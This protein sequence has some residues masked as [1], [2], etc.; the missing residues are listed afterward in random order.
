M[1]ISYVFLKKYDPSLL[2]IGGGDIFILC[3]FISIKILK[4]KGTTAR[5]NAF[6]YKQTILRSF[7]VEHYVKKE[8]KVVSR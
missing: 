3:L 7:D 6:T 8:R 5:T 4:T 2:I 1:I